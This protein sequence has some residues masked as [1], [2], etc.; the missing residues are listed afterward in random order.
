MAII[1]YFLPYLYLF[2]A[3]IQL[4]SRAAGPEIRRVPGG[5]PVAI[6]LASIGLASTIATIVLSTIPGEDE[7]HKALAIVKVV[8]GTAALAGAGVAI[9]LWGSYK[10]RRS[11][12]ILA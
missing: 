2:A 9:F 11:R 1:A 3:M 8:G 4:Q 12:S 5:R 10:S 7:P 6:A